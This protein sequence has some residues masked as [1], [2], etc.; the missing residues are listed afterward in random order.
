MSV[1]QKPHSTTQEETLL[2]RSRRGKRAKRRGKDG[3]NELAR[4]L[5]ERLGTVIRRNLGQSRDGGH[6]LLLPGWSVEVKR[7]A[8]P[9]LATWWQQTLLQA[10]NAGTRPVL[11]YRLDRGAW[12]F[13]VRLADLLSACSDQSDFLTA[14]LCIDGFCLIVRENL[15]ATYEEVKP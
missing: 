1:M 13:V 11:A 7:A 10:R 3:E 4:L 15:P 6:D 9:Q 8:S 14:R 2:E 12:C 5:T